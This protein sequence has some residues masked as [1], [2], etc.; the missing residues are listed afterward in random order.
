MNISMFNL[1]PYPQNKNYPYEASKFTSGLHTSCRWPTAVSCQG[2]SNHTAIPTGLR[3]GNQ[4]ISTYQYIQISNH[5]T[6]QWRH[7]ELT[8]V[9]NHQPHDWLLNRLFTRRSKKTSKLRVTGLCV[10]NSPVTGEFPAQKA[11][12]AENDSIWWRHHDSN[13]LW[14]NWLTKN[15]KTLQALWPDT[16][17]AIASQKG[18]KQLNALEQSHANN[19]TLYE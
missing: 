7:N 11:S 16:H 19:Y 5:F 14:L 9:S 3:N 2:I 1:N 4:T 8:G 13:W 15:I 6:L 10:G 17:R 18:L 12:N